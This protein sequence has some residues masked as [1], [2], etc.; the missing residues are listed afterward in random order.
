MAKIFLE[1]GGDGKDLRSRCREGFRRLL[2]RCGFGGRM[3]SL[4]ASGGRGSAFRD[5]LTAHRHAALGEFIA[6]LVDSEGP[7]ADPALPWAHLLERDG[8]SR[9]AGADDDQA[10]LMITC[11]ESWIAADR[12]A[13]RAEFGGGL[14]ESE[15]PGPETL[16]S[17]APRE[18]LGAL[19]RATEACRHPYRKGERSFRALAA[20]DPDIVAA[21]LPSFRRC[22][23]VL[24]RR[25]AADA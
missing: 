23:E 4:V 15:L 14:R 17:R 22:R 5:F 24:G 20:V 7:V 18:V 6:M 16:E 25:L 2:E 8:W 3:P 21:Y 1:G 11:M 19:D 13:L 10:L 9:P 12:A